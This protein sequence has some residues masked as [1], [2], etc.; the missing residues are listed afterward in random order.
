MQPIRDFGA[1]VTNSYAANIFSVTMKPHF[2]TQEEV[3]NAW[4]RVAMGN[5]Y[6]SHSSNAKYNITDTK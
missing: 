2:H 5:Y 6:L 3:D 1:G 4:P